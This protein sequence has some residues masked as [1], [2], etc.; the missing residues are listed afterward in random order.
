MA[1]NTYTQPEL[2]EKLKEEIKQSD[3]GGRPG[4]WSARKSQLL[5]HEYEAQGGGYT[6]PKTDAQK[7]LDEWT[8]EE[9]T[10][11]DGQPAERDGETHRYLPKEAWD[12]LT[13]A[14]RKATD[15][16]KV[17]GSRQG[18]QYIANTEAAASARESAQ[19]E[20][21][22]PGPTAAKKTATR[23]KAAHKA[24]AK[25]KAAARPKA[26]DKPKA[27]ARPKP[28]EKPKAA[29]KPKAADKPRAAGKP[30]NAGE[31]AA[32]RPAARGRKAPAR[33]NRTTSKSKTAS[34][35]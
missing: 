9:W 11:R 4:Q 15:R 3:R 2:R 23:P 25:P 21:T 8:E 34:T 30:K 32:K 1:K 12:K 5:A 6:G 17:E 16:K 13:P 19:E 26:A 27:A 29:V 10:T 24:A 31:P 35:S 20:K 18:K 22:V 7:H 33:A 14:Q 28:A